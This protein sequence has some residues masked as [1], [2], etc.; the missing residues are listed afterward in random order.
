MPWFFWLWMD[1]LIGIIGASVI[2]TWS[3][4]LVRDTGHLLI[5][6]NPDQHLS[7]QLRQEIGADRDLLTDLHAWRSGVGHLGASLSV[8]IGGNRRPEDFHARSRPFS[9]RSHITC[10]VH[11]P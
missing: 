10:E 4:G 5:D 1:P 3:L 9:T 11:A 6:M 8:A 2:A 7:D